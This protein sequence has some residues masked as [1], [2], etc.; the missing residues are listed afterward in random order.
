MREEHGPGGT[1][2]RVTYRVPG[3]RYATYDYLRADG[4]PYLRIPAFGLGG[5]SRGHGRIQLVGADRMVVEE[6]KTAGTWFRRWIRD[7]ARDQKR[8]FLFMDSRYVVSHLVPIKAKRVHVIYVMH[9]LHVQ[10]PVPLGLRRHQVYERVFDRIESMDA[11]VTLTRRQRDDIAERRGRTSNMFVVPNPV[12]LPPAPAEPPA[13]DPSGSRHRPARAAEAPRRRDRRV[14]A[15]R[16]GEVPA[17][18]LD[19]YGEGSRAGGPAGR[20][21]PPRARR[22]TSRCAASTPRRATPRGRASAFLMTSSFEGYPLS[23]LESMS[24]GCPVVSYDIKY[25]P[26]EQITDGVDGFLVPRGDVAALAERVVELLRSPELV[27]R[28]SAAAR[29][30]APRATGRTSFVAPLGRGAAR[31]RRGARR[32]R[33]RIDGR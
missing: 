24:R 2:F 32:H 10:R 4:S 31:G 13:R 1:P 27:A 5:G 18:R 8:T 9:N 11:F 30:T 25:G 26:R 22:A 17:A 14:R 29:A 15:R 21:R 23:T 3:E 19:I 7:M 6:L 33:T 12:D 28:M 20:D 16:A